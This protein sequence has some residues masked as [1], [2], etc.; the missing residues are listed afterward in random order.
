LRLV[1]DDFAWITGELVA[2]AERHAKGR[3]VSVLEGGYDTGALARSVTAH[4][5]ALAG[6][7]GA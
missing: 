5:R 1:E 2:V 4:L 3:V 6:E 7:D